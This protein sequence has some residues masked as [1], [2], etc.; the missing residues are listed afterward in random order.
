MVLRI[1]SDEMMNYHLHKFAQS[2][3]FIKAA[4]DARME[5]P[6]YCLSSRISSHPLSVV[7]CQ[8]QRIWG[9]GVGLIL[10]SGV[11]ITISEKVATNR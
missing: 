9:S 6:T 8:L 10:T 5:E 1:D 11:P 2:P 3:M 4:D 7:R